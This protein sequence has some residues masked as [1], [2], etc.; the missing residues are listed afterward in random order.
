[1]VKKSKQSKPDDKQSKPN[2]NAPSKSKIKVK[3]IKSKIKVIEKDDSLE[4]EIEE[5][6]DEIFHGLDS[7]SGLD[8]PEVLGANVNLASAQGRASFAG[9]ANPVSNAPEKET[10][11]S[12]QLYA[13]G[14]NLG[15][16]R[17]TPYAA[18]VAALDKANL[19]RADV[20]RAFAMSSQSSFAENKAMDR[21]STNL[22]HRSLGEGRD[23]KYEPKDLSKEEPGKRKQYWV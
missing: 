1:M 17:R 12:E 11:T 10:L 18:N 20:G 6:D 15:T 14:K 8:S 5:A 22:R 19:G 23:D 13:I 4:E 2:N 3:E 21:V 9:R 7:T 16:E